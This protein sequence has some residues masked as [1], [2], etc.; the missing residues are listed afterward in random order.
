M[1][2]LVVTDN[3]SGI[4]EDLIPRL[5]EPDFS[6]RQGG[7]GLGLWIV[8]QIVEKHRGYVEVAS[9]PGRGTEFRIQFPLIG[10]DAS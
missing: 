8:G 7:S 10:E 2:E 6:A 3:G 5:F 9:S 4:E 1:F